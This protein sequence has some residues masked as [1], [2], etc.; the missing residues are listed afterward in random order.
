MQLSLKVKNFLR[1][2]Q[3]FDNFAKIAKSNRNGGKIRREEGSR[4]DSLNLLMTLLEN[5]PILPSVSSIE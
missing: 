1:V 5:M 3:G 4:I 2:E